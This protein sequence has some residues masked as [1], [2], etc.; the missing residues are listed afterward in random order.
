MFCGYTDATTR[1]RE[2][3]ICMKEDADYGKYIVSFSDR[4]A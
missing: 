1:F 3:K 4:E 2:W